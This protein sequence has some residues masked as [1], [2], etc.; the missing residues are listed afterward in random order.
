M[1]IGKDTCGWIGTRVGVGAQDVVVE[2][3]VLRASTE[4]ISA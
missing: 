1:R 4:R 2:I 3:G